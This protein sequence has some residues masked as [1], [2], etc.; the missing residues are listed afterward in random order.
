MNSSSE[1]EDSDGLSSQTDFDHLE[2][3]K[4]SVHFNNAVELLSINDFQGKLNFI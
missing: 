2:R 1:S 3:I 4:E